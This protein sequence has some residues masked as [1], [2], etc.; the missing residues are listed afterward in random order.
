MAA[1][2]SCSTATLIHRELIDE[3]K[4]EVTKSTSNSNINGIGGV[5]KGKIVE[6]RL[7]SRNKEKSIMVNATVVDDIMLL[8][9]KEK[10]RFNQLTKS[11]AEALRN[12]EGF[13]KVTENNFQQV[14]GGKIQMLIGQNVGQDYFPHEI[15]TFT[16]GLKVSMHQIKLYDENRYLGLSGRFPSQFSTMYTINDHP[17]VLAIQ[18]F[19]RQYEQEEEHVFQEAASAKPPR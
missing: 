19:P 11:S 6:I 9:I 14:P 18:E 1:F 15:A 13:A 3:G 17:K 16:C 4:L 5:A 2:D 8:P 7:D 10:E 12:R